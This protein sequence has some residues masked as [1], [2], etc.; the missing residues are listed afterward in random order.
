MTPEHILQ[1]WA[2]KF[3]RAMI[4]A[5]CDVEAHDRSRPQSQWHHATERARG[6]KAGSAD[7]SIVCRGISHRIE[8]KYG[9]AKPSDDQVRAGR[10][11]ERAGGRW[12]WC[13]SVEGV[14]QICVAWDIPLRPNASLVAQD[15]DLRVIARVEKDRAKRAASRAKPRPQWGH[16]ASDPNLAPQPASE[17]PK[18][19][20]RRPQK[21]ALKALAKARAEGV[22]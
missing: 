13:N 5:P 16:D 10:D 4:D 21:A 15:Y 6:L 1:F 17:R 3:L 18:P 7:L 12:D 20:F 2:V 14:R 11:V 8:L 19:V 22:F 9:A